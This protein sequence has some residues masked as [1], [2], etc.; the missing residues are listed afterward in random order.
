MS[1]LFPEQ[2]HGPY[3]L[4]RGVDQRVVRVAE[5]GCVAPEAL[6]SERL[7]ALLA[8]VAGTDFGR[9]HGLRVGM[10]LADY[11]RAVPVR[12]YDAL[13]PWLARVHAGEA[14]VL[15]QAPVRSLLKTSGTTG[16]AKLLPVTDPYA[17]EVADGQTLWR[18]GLVRDHEAVTRGAALTLV[19]PAVEGVL[20][21]GLAYGSNTGR[22]HEAQPW[23][24][25][26]RF[27]VPL[28]VTRIPDPTLRLYASLRFALQARL[29]TITTANPS[30][31]LLVCRRLL[32]WQEDLAGDLVDGTLRRGPAQDLARWLGPR[33]RLALRLRLRRRP[34][35]RDWRPAQLWPLAV[36]NCWKGG[37]APFFLARLPEALGAALPVR[38]VGLT[39]SEGYFAFPNS[40]GEEGGVAWLGGHLLEFLDE[41]GAP[42]WAWELE[43]GRSYRLVISTHAGLY[44]YDLADIVEVSGFAG[45]APVLRF[46][47]KAGNV[48]NVTGEKLTEDQLVRAVRQALGGA[49]LVGFTVGYQMAEVPALRLYVEGEPPPGLA[50]R[51]DAALGE[52]NVEYHDKRQSG[53]LGPPFVERAPEGT[54]RRYRERRAA[55]GAPDGQIKDPILALDEAAW[56]RIT[57]PPLTGGGG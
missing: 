8:Q 39:A 41:D 6:Q 5:R 38:E 7:Q 37:P 27:P 17:A 2:G 48:L 15:T 30:T 46:V 16:A 22:M 50:A 51:L 47:R 1:L 53:R 23:M 3:R 34:A 56:A 33:E 26:V 28:A 14:R 29:S 10:G 21:S 36:V 12:G 57:G 11:R 9:E 35:P 24:V 40:D 32:E 13:L 42:R 49:P 54:Y 44:R 18:L 19:S 31:L 4:V 20:P 43:A 25:R 45:R 52:A 55:E